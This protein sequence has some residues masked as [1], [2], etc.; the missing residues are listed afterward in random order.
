MKE[1]LEKIPAQYEERIIAFIDILGFRTLINATVKDDIL[2][3]DKLQSLIDALSL[4][5]EEFNIVSKNSELPFS[6]EIT[7]F[8]DSIV[9]SLRRDYSLGLLTIFEVLKRIQ[10]KLVK[11]K[12]YY[13]EE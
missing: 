5:K 13:G 1:T 9:L 12:S 4:I 8:S 11:K 6:F 7:Y 2:Q 10:I 3:T